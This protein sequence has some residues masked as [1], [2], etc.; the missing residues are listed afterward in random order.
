[1]SKLDIIEA[2][3]VAKQDDDDPVN[4]LENDAAYCNTVVVL[5]VFD[6]AAFILDDGD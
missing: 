1:M 3:V 2:Q 4:E 6:A 5:A